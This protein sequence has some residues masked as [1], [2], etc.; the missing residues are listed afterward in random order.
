MPGPVWL[1]GP[2]EGVPALLQPVAHALVEAEE[3]IRAL[4]T[5][6]SPEA[7]WRRPG[8]AASVGYHVCHAVG[9]LDRLF[10]YARGEGLSEAQLA[11]LAAEKTLSAKSA[12][13]SQLVEQFAAAIEHAL[14]QL[15]VTDE[16]RLLEKREVGRARL[17]SNVIG[18]LVHAGD[19]TYRHVG[20]AITTAKIVTGG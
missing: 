14:E 5:S 16:S 2:I 11:A 12:T 17:P 10:T 18:L 7:V 3:D 13:P 9:S 6:L 1:R 19:H 15:R 20:Q 8:G 4:V